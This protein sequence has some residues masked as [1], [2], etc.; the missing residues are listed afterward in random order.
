MATAAGI[1]AC[2]DITF[3]PAAVGPEGGLAD[4]AADALESSTDAVP[5]PATS[6]CA[7]SDA[8][9][10]ADFDDD[11][12]LAAHWTMFGVSPTASVTLDSNLALSQPSSMHMHTE[13]GGPA[14]INCEYARAVRDLSDLG[15][16]THARLSYDVFLGSVDGGSDLAR[17]GMGVG[18]AITKSGCWFIMG[19][20][21]TGCTHL[22]QVQTDA[23][24][25]QAGN[26]NTVFPLPKGK[27]WVH[28]ELVA[29]LDPLAP[30]VTYLVDNVSCG[31]PLPLPAQC[32]SPTTFTIY[33]GTF[34]A[35]G[36]GGIFEGN[37]DNV[38]FRGN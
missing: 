24:I 26:M 22:L 6:F 36:D 16:K 11:G 15:Q 19:L 12:G 29:D 17:Q 34:C 4:G 33:P 8:A 10:C 3:G 38:E 2:S 1:G 13:T 14:S 23:G 21:S 32:A 28:V 20:G 30:T 35:Q 18:A 7:Q 25:I 27:G 9:F 5:P 37:L 31:A